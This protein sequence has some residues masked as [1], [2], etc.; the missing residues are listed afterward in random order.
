[1]LSGANAA[2]ILKACHITLSDQIQKQPELKYLS[3]TLGKPLIDLTKDAGRTFRVYKLLAGAGNR[4]AYYRL[5]VFYQTGYGVEK[6]LPHA[7]DC[8]K[9]AQDHHPKASSAYK[10]LLPISPPPDIPT[11]KTWEFKSNIPFKSHSDVFLGMGLQGCVCRDKWQ[12]EEVVAVKYFSGLDR[13]RKSSWVLTDAKTNQSDYLMQVKALCLKPPCLVLEYM[14]GKNLTAFLK[15]YSDI[16]WLSRYRIAH[17]IIQGVA[18][19]HKH[20]LLHCDL[21]GNNIMVME[22]P[23]LH[24]KLFDFDSLVKAPPA[25]RRFDFI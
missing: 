21:K 3:S 13:R 5:G 12:K 18:Y 19:L 20:G 17:D 1:M 14:P 11:L 7:R 16:T 8:F 24:A 25:E 9:L 2:I 22:W 6:S 10:S 15:A 23:C 4:S